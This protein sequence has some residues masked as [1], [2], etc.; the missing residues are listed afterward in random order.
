MKAAVIGAA[1]LV[2]ASAVSA[3]AAE[4]PPP[5]SGKKHPAEE[6]GIKSL[7]SRVETSIRFYNFGSQ[8]VKVY[9]IDTQGKRVLKATLKS[10]EQSEQKTCL[11]HPWLTAD[12][13]DNASAIYFPDA[14]A[15]T[16]T[17]GFPFSGGPPPGYPGGSPLGTSASL[18]SLGALQN[19]AAQEELKLGKEQIGKVEEL[20]RKDAESARKESDARNAL[21]RPISDYLS[22]QT[23]ERNKATQQAASDLLRPEQKKRLEQIQR[24]QGTRLFT[25]AQ[26]LDALRLTPEQRSKLDAIRAED[27][28][29]SS[30][31]RAAASR[32]GTDY[33]KQQ[34]GLLKARY[35]KI[36]ALLTPEQ[37]KTWNELVGPPCTGV[38]LSSPRG[39]RSSRATFTQDQEFAIGA[40]RAND[41]RW[42]RARTYQLS[43]MSCA[44]SSYITEKAFQEELRLTPEQ[45]GKLTAIS[46]R[47]D[48]TVKA[49]LTP[50]QLKRY[51]GIS[52]QR[53][54]TM[55]GPAGAFRFREIP[56]SLK[57]TEEQKHKILAIGQADSKVVAALAPSG[58]PLPQDKLQAI[59]KQTEAKL[60]E[61]LT[62]EQ[63][64]SLKDFLGESFKGRDFPP[65]FPLGG[66]RPFAPST[67]PAKDAKP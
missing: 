36:V 7:D 35:D 18:S 3:A 61:V 24:Q 47:D 13:Q 46:R 19:R 17:L 22:Q 41:R 2:L 5:S 57:L 39:G 15:R 66:P 20:A 10:R 44:G 67:P 65:G 38:I 64:T 12:E 21:I 9:W 26:L 49:V 32:S 29:S 50:D 37:L 54:M 23:T 42:L 6:K 31:S 52:L 62:A 56:E 16:I 58:T 30:W 55:Y 40:S 1:I 34:A 43:Q 53:L 4:A 48:A 51:Q 45:I 33:E 8:T 63:K 14:Q 59:D 60:A 11:T 25:D 28:R 27:S